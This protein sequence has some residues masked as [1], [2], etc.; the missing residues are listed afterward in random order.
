[1][2]IPVVL[3]LW[4]VHFYD[5]LKVMYSNDTAAKVAEGEL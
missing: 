5:L 4:T 2:D 3:K 1:M